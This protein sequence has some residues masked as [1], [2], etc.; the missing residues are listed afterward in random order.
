[1]NKMFIVHFHFQPAGRPLQPIIDK[2]NEMAKAYFDNSRPIYCAK[3][4]FV[5][6]IASL[7]D[8]RKYLKAFAGAV[9]QNP[10]SICPQHQMLT[11]RVIKG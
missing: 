7:G 2:M 6:E 11:P 4:G 8:I 5:D 9:Y 3:E 10:R 1:M